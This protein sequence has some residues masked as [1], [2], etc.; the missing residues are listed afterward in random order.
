MAGDDVTISWSVDLQ[1]HVSQPAN[2]AAKAMGE[3]SS[4]A[5]GLSSHMNQLQEATG[6]ATEGAHG[7]G[8]GFGELIP[9]IAGAELAIEGA[10]KAFE[11]FSETGKELIATAI[12][13][14]E[15]VQHLTEVFGALSGAGE[16]GAGE[17]GKAIFAMTRQIASQL[18]Q[19]EA[20]I[21]SWTRSLMA[22]GVTDMTRLQESLRATAGAEALV[23]G[24]GEKVRSIL[25]R[26]NEASVKGTKL[27]FNVSQ[28]EGTGITEEE[29]LKHL[30]M[31]PRAFELARKN[32][33]ITGT[34]IADAMVAVLGEK[35]KGPLEGQMGEL[36]TVTTKAKDAFLH[37]FD[38][39]EPKP[40]VDGLREFFSVFDAANPSGKVIRDTIGGA[41]NFIFRVAGTV[42]VWLKNAFLHLMIWGLQAALFVKPLIA[43]FKEWFQ[44]HDGLNIL[45]TSLKGLGII[46]GSVAAF[47]ILVTGTAIAFGAAVNIA[48]GVIIAAV[49]GG[50]GYIVGLVPRAGEA[51][52]DLAFHAVEAA[53]G[54]VDGLV[55]GIKNG[56]GLVVDAVKNMGKGAWNALKSTLGISSPSKLMF[57]AGM[58][59]SEGFAGGIA[60]GTG[61]VEDSSSRMSA[62][63][64]PRA[65]VGGVG[66]ATVTI[67]DIVVHVQGGA[68]ARATGEAIAEVVEERLASIMN[69]LSNMGGTAP[70]PA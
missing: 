28:L 63:A 54:F 33:Q 41:F 64:V 43:S 65:G 23:E 42:F 47:F 60:A 39:V 7:A 12:E 5:Q 45:M 48:F 1:D 62:A 4:S 67:G 8:V 17:A 29:L 20:T 52:G 46:L 31:T 34:Q 16:E 6:H 14:S 55:N 51:L 9:E 25:A 61:S 44:Q 66:G 22:A 49:V 56:V 36:A 30:G 26:L 68:D 19:S 35:A 59:T 70:L 11:F 32:G 57:E 27:R 37:L 18:P 38:G 21:Q 3:A 13:A 40:L 2:A 15:Q 24:G 69:R 53:K 50:V 58:H 10:K